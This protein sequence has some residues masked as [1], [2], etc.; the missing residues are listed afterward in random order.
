MINHSSAKTMKIK[1]LHAGPHQHRGRK[2]HISHPHHLAV[3]CHVHK[4][5]HSKNSPNN[6]QSSVTRRRIPR[7]PAVNYAKENPSHSNFPP[8]ET[9]QKIQLISRCQ[10]NKS[11][12]FCCFFQQ[13]NKL[14]RRSVFICFHTRCGSI[15]SAASAVGRRPFAAL[16]TLHGGWGH[17]FP[18]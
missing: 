10:R 14:G 3:A 7:V 18:I 6:V 11:A 2:L 15:I 5:I 13:S 12:F 8:A 1:W 4:L 16:P 9:R 17:I